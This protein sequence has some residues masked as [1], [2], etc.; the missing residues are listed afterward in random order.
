MMPY[1][2]IAG[3]LQ[4]GLMGLVLLAGTAWS[5]SQVQRVPALS[6]GVRGGAI[7]PSSD[8]TG[9]LGPQGAVFMRWGLGAKLQAEAAVAYQRYIT[10][11]YLWKNNL[12]DVTKRDNYMTHLSTAQARLVFAPVRYATWNPFVYGGVGYEYCNVEDITPRRGSWD[13][14]GRTADIPLGIGAR[15]QLAERWG[16]EG[17]GGYTFSFSKKTDGST[18]EAPAGGSLDENSANN[19]FEFNVGLT[20]DITL[21]AVIE[22]TAKPMPTKP[23]KPVAPAPAAPKVEAPKDTDGDG[24]TDVDESTVYFTNPK[25]ADSDGDGLSDGDEIRV[26][27]TN[28]NQ[29]DT[30]QGGIND[31]DEVRRGTDPLAAAD[32]KAVEKRAVPAPAVGQFTFPVVYYPTG[33]YML[34]AQAKADLNKASKILLENPGVLLNVQGHTDN[35]GTPPANIKLS[36]ARAEV[37]KDYL[38]QQGVASWRIMSSYYGDTKPAATNGT[39]EGKAK[40]RRTELIQAK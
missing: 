30:D 11:D 27:R 5:G 34:S 13:G 28:A 36:R 7:L 26:Y 9:K 23:V 17:S 40:N 8:L 1:R 35:A 10:E 24:L 16:L 37:V 31:G 21:G 20:Y 19:F 2:R 29:A 12:L 15:Y 38:V 32:D 39:P 22:P 4:A 18:L 14:I 6:I 33:G 25:V 3:L